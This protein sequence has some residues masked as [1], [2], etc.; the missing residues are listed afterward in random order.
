[1]RVTPQAAVPD[2][3]EESEGELWIR[4]PSWTRT[5]RS[6]LVCGAPDPEAAGVAVTVPL[7]PV[8]GRLV[9]I[10]V[11]LDDDEELQPVRVAAAAAARTAMTCDVE[12]CIL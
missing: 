6:P 2:T 1:V 5:V 8:P 10:P 9:A 11:A 3:A 4:R 12:A 7:T